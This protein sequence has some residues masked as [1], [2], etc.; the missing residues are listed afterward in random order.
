MANFPNMY[1]LNGKFPSGF[2]VLILSMAKIFMH[3]KET[4]SR[5]YRPLGFLVNSPKALD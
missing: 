1:F 2:L 5:Y 3:F 4:V